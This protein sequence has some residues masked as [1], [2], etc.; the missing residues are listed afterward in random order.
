MNL[1]DRDRAQELLTEYTKKPSL[2]NHAL[3]VEAALGEYARRLG[4]DVATWRITGLLHDFDYERWP[5]PEDHPLKGSEILR[6]AG[7]PEEIVYAILSH[8]QYLG[9]ERKSPLDRALFAVDER[10]APGADCLNEIL[11]LPVMT[12]KR[13]GRRIGSAAA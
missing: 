1:L 9:L 5:E 2:V 8:A 6:S 3:A 10:F 4:G 7:Y 12:G 11:Q 13:D